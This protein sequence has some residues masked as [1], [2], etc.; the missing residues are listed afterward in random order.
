MFNISRWFTSYVCHRKSYEIMLCVAFDRKNKNDCVINRDDQKVPFTNLIQMTTTTTTTTV[1]FIHMDKHLHIPASTLMSWATECRIR[2]FAVSNFRTHGRIMVKAQRFAFKQETGDHGVVLGSHVTVVQDVQHQGSTSL[3][4]RYRFGVEGEAMGKQDELGG[5]GD[6]S[7]RTESRKIEGKSKVEQVVSWGTGDES[8]GAELR[9]IGGKPTE[10]RGFEGERV[11]SREIGDHLIRTETREIRD[12]SRVEGKPAELREFARGFTTIVLVG[13][14]GRPV[15]LKEKF[16]LAKDAVK[17]EE[18]MLRR[19]GRAVD[20]IG[21]RM[22]S[23]APHRVLTR[24]S[25]EDTNQHVTHY[26]YA[27]FFQDALAEDERYPLKSVYVEYVKE[28]HKNQEG[29]IYSFDGPDGTA[30]LLKSNGELV[31]RGFVTWSRND[32]VDAKL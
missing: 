27:T 28:M 12:E 2:F 8:R 20:E 30:L 4:F 19:D 14:N 1:Q 5:S 13:E 32:Q 25:D 15:E 9:G 23:R 11:K 26:R 22:G 29:V 17:G 21:A 16:E 24:D 10:S 6:E 3:T 18:L 31:C 7:R